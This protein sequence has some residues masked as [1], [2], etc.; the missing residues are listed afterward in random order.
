[1]NIS[2]TKNI[3]IKNIIKLQK[4]SER[5]KQNMICIEGYHELIIALESG[6]NIQNIYYSEDFNKK[7]L[8]IPEKIND[9]II[10][11]SSMVFKKIS[12][13]ENPDGFLALAVH[14]K[15]N[16]NK[17]K[18]T[19]NPLIII[20]EGV[21]KPGNLGA[22]SRTV[23]AVGAT[24]LI[25]SNPKTNIFN[26]NVIRSSLGTVFTNKIATGTNVEVL[27]WLKKNKIKIFATTP[28]AKKIYTE[29]NLN[30]PIAIVIG[31]EHEGLSKY[32]LASVDEKIKI[33]MHGKMDS[34]NASVSAGIVLFEAKRQRS[35]KIL[36]H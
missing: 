19:K 25:I 1:M 9:K 14:P 18:I 24:A 33:P 5:K 4:S 20:L 35:K 26:P 7:N 15:I 34:L 16:L 31:T 36:T 27:E 28:N 29:S 3:Q 2:S 32:W 23:D 17:I 11:V 8:A 30:G 22:I 21:E 12:Y 13:R 10:N 6:I